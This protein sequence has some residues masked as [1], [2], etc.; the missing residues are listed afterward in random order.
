[1]LKLNRGKGEWYC[2]YVILCPQLFEEYK[3]TSAT[4][5]TWIL[6]ATESETNYHLI[7]KCIV[8]N[9]NI[10]YTL[11]CTCMKTFHAHIYVYT[12]SKQSQNFL[13][14]SSWY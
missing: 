3:I 4:T 11:I 12:C 5:E 2:K 9:N 1:M 6:Q 13:Q 14:P 7:E 10:S 8:Q